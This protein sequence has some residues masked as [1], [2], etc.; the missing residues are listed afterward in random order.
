MRDVSPPPTK[1]R[2]TS[3]DAASIDTSRGLQSERQSSQEDSLDS[4]TIRIYSW[5]IN[6]INPFL[7]KSITSF[8]PSKPKP[9]H[10]SQSGSESN[11]DASHHPQGPSLREFLRRHRWPHILCLQEVKIAFTDTSTQAAVKRAVNDSADGPQY[12]VFFTLPTDC[13]NARGRGGRVYGVSTIIRKDV[14]ETRVV[15][16]RTVDWDAEGRVSVVELRGGL[17]VWN[18]YAVNG[19]DNLWRDSESGAVL[20]SRHDKKL[21]VQRKI[22]EDCMEAERSGCHVVIVGDLNVAPA[23]IDGHPNL[24]TFP[25]QHVVNRRHFNTRFFL[26]PDGLRAVD[27]WR[28]LKGDDKRY[29]YFP[30]GRPWGSSCDRVDLI[31]ASRSLV[32]SGKVVDVEIFDSEEERGPS[33]HVPLAVEIQLASEEISKGEKYM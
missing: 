13:F 29:T 14:L 7:Q 3:S 16:V 28:S 20:G 12:E 25:E 15:R 32:E 1:R 27:V 9:P 11:P 19:T 24:R 30:R 18:V 2:K 31:I 4:A 22:V 33:D 23:R 21:L 5:N 26:D 6:G 8:F 17:H 10:N